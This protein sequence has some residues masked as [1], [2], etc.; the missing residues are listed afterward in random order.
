MVSMW[1]RRQSAL[2]AAAL[3]ACVLCA[4]AVQPRP[5]DTAE[6][7]PAGYAFQPFGSAS[8]RPART[9]RIVAPNDRFIIYVPEGGD[10]LAS[11]AKQFLGGEDRAWVISDFNNISEARPAQPLVIPLQALNPTGVSVNGYQTI[12]ILCYHRFG[13]DEGKMVLSPKAFAQQMEYLHRNGYRVLRLSELPAFLGGKRQLPARAV[14]LTIDDGYSSMYHQ[15]YPVLKRY[16]FPATVFAYT[17]FIGARDA[18]TWDQM[19]EMVGSGLIDVQAHSKS[20]SNLTLRMPGESDGRYRERLSVEAATPR[21]VLRRKL[22]VNV[23]SYAY[24]YGDANATVIEQLAKTDYKMALT[25][26][27]GGNAFFTPPLL[28]RRTMVLGDEDLEAFKAQLQVFTAA[29]LR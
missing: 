5:A 14:V 8:T 10:T 26:D 2:I 25:V 9:D 22:N 11:I 1:I 24:P 13:S 15:A 19:R 28:L 27:P 16:G 17:D 7:A 23:S 21:D 6:A 12:P 20:H 3:P 29:D 18:L 4:C